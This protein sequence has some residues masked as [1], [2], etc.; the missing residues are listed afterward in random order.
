MKKI[1]AL[2]LVIGGLALG[3][4]GFTELKNSS[5]GIE[6]GNLEIKAQDKESSTTAY[7]MMGAGVLMIIGGASW[8]GRS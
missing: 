5:K 2:L 8:G 6:I 7:L 3:Y 4:F 1:I